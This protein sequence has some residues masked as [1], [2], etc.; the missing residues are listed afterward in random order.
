MAR[1]EIP[2]F[3]GFHDPIIIAAP[4]MDALW[5]LWRWWCNCGRAGST[6]DTYVGASKSADSHAEAKNAAR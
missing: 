4:K 5:T 2:P 3:H 6:P 1:D